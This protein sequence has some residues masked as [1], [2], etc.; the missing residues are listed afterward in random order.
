MFVITTMKG[1]KIYERFGWKQVDVIDVD[2]GARGGTFEGYGMHRSL[3]LL[4]TQ[5]EAGQ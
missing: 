2:L 3:C 4:R 5:E 1:R